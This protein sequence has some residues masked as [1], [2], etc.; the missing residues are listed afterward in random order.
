ME[1]ADN[2]RLTATGTYFVTFC[3]PQGPSDLVFQAGT[4]DGTTTAGTFGVDN[5]TLFLWPNAYPVTEAPP[6]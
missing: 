2:G 3:M 1:V 6:T 4:D 5:V